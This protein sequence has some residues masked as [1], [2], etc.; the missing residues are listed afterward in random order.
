MRPKK[1]GRPTLPSRL[2][3]GRTPRRHV[4]RFCGL[5]ATRRAKG[6]ISPHRGALTTLRLYQMT[7]RKNAV[8]YDVKSADDRANEKG[9][10]ESRPRWYAPRSAQWR[11]AR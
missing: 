8:N 4:E 1:A 5:A 7:P 6:V 3:T 2:R 9:R 11:R 10:P